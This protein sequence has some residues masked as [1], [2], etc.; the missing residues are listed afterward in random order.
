MET[1]KH[2]IG[3]DLGGTDIKAGLV[4]SEGDVSCRVVVPTDVET[5]GP[6]VVAA[7]ITEAVRQVLV[8]AETAASNATQQSLLTVPEN[9]DPMIQ[10]LKLVSDSV[11]RDS[12]SPKLGSSTFHQTFRVGATS[13]LLPMSTQNYQNYTPQNVLQILINSTSLS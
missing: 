10:H 12:L 4:S 11:H 5:G 13:F 8:K 7:R 2:S 6:K 9:L 3:V 1:T